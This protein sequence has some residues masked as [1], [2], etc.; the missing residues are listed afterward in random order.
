MRL[1]LGVQG[2][3]DKNAV[4][5]AQLTHECVLIDG[6]AQVECETLRYGAPVPVGPFWGGT[7]VDD[8]A[9]V[10]VGPLRALENP[11]A[12]LRD[13]AVVRKVKQSYEDTPGLYEATEKEILF[14]TDFTAW[15]TN[16]KGIQGK[17][18]APRQ[19]R[20]ALVCCLTML[21]V[22]GTVDKK[23]LERL[24]HSTTHP[25]MHRK[26]F[27]SIFSAAYRFMT[28][29]I[30]GPVYRIP[31]PVLQELVA[32][33]LLLPLADA[34][35]RWDV[36]CEISATDATPV[37]GGAVRG[38]VPYVYARELYRASEFCGE[39]TRLDWDAITEECL[40]SRMR[41]PARQLLQYIPSIRWRDL[42]GGAFR[43]K[44]HVN[45]QEL[46]AVRG[47]LQRLVVSRLG[48]GT[49]HVVLVDSRVVVGAWGKGRSSSKRLNNV[50]RSCLGW[51]TLGRVRL[52]L[53]WV[54][55]DLNP[56]DDP[57]RDRPLR[58]PEPLNP[59]LIDDFV[60][61]VGD[62]E[63]RC[64]DLGVGLRGELSKKEFSKQDVW[65]V[66]GVR[67]G[68]GDG[69][70]GNNNDG[71]PDFSFVSALG[72]FFDVGG[73]EF[74][75]ATSDC[76]VRSGDVSDSEP[77]ATEAA[78]PPSS[79]PNEDPPPQSGDASCLHPPRLAQRGAAW[80]NGAGTHSLGGLS[81]QGVRGALGGRGCALQMR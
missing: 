63:A 14:E 69:G 66:K 57:S 48:R 11:R 12:G 50:L 73:E 79:P 40:P 37:R 1:C 27:L 10:Q 56:S 28:R 30:Y 67:G 38:E 19:R 6:G 7:Y 60:K 17:A 21:S 77:E 23:T 2:M 39:Y 22:Q 44:E 64:T 51:S 81:C 47:E 62:M 4:D 29:M 34:E 31:T 75:N 49:R 8:H 36:D 16:V 65:N 9:A 5:V 61:F 35:L 3:G 25:F 78:G 71:V 45:I 26:D 59:T 46:Q 70:A 52:L 80:Q 55:T 43:F 53:V 18:G 24:V 72:E 41:R 54:P 76:K 68:G 32:A 15:G 13:E 42:G 33:A 20:S 74:W 58:P